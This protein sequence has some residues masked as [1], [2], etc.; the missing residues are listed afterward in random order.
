VRHSNSRILLRSRTHRGSC[1]FPWVRRIELRNQGLLGVAGH[2]HCARLRRSGD[3]AFRGCCWRFRLS[4]V[5]FFSPSLSL[6]LSL[7]RSLSLSLSRSLSLSLSLP[8]PSELCRTISVAFF[9]A[10]LTAL[11]LSLCLSL[12][13]SHSPHPRSLASCVLCSVML[14][15]RFQGLVHWDTCCSNFVWM[16]RSKTGRSADTDWMGNESWMSVAVANLLVTRMTLLQR[17]GFCKYVNM[18][19][20]QPLS[21]IMDRRCGRI[22]THSV[23]LGQTIVRSLGNSIIA[24]DNILRCHC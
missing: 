24:M 2:E 16:S 10:R 6:S 22:R 9:L 4:V 7:A 13:F 23:N 17:L 3:C 20:E 15:M 1:T 12:S 18:L 19:L 21:S 8:F 14:R 5:L 11:F